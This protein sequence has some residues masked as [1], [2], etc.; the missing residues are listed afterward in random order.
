MI[1]NILTGKPAQNRIMSKVAGSNNLGWI[2]VYTKRFPNQITEEFDT[3]KTEFRPFIQTRIGGNTTMLFADI[4]PQSGQ[5]T[6][7]NP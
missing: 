2:E 4:L 3:L 1:L 5:F 6:N 7:L